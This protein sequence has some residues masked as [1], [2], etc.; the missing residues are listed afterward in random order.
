MHIGIAGPIATA[1]IGRLLDR[2]TTDLPAGFPGAPF[3]TTLIAELISRGHR[4]SAFTLSRDMPL[5]ERLSVVA[6]GSSLDLHYI[7]MRP[8]AWPFNGRLPGRIVDLY[9]FERRGLERAMRA[10]APEL[11][12]AHWSYEFAWAALSS[13]L[14][15]VITCHDS[16]VLVARMAS[17]ATR[18]GYRWLR[19][20]MARHVLARARHVT[21]VSPYMRDQIQGW[22]K[23]SVAV[24]PNPIDGEAFAVQRVPTPGRLQICMVCNGWSR[25]KNAR[26]ALLAFAQIGQR[27]PYAEFAVCGVDFEPGGV[28]E[29]WWRAQGSPAKVHFLGPLAH[30]AV[31]QLMAGSDI[32]LHPALEE[33]FG[34]VVAE[35]MAAGLPVVGG[36]RSGAI[37][38]LV[39][40]SGNLVDVSAP[41][42]ISDALH[43]LADDRDS[44]TRSAADAKRMTWARFSQGVVASSYETIYDLVRHADPAPA[45]R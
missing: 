38:W 13:G 14:P 15:H 37:P 44:A 16:P 32:L 17:G 9:A 35:A 4:V 39:G 31:L 19:V 22:C 1:D 33:S 26:A 8:R 7:P 11:V 41:Q 27:K 36:A 6:H 45:P 34:V 43:R 2:S 29:L 40:T 3:L 12:H 30:T 25:R 20:A 23:P 21:A 18:R 10:A 28:A 24:V 5:D 42:A